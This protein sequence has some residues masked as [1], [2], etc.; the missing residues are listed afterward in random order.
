MGQ[1]IILVGLVALLWGTTDA[2]FKRYV[3]HQFYYSLCILVNLLGS[4][5]FFLL[6]D[7]MDVSGLQTLTNSLSLIV[8]TLVSGFYLEREFRA[9]T[10]LGIL[11]VLLGVLIY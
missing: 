1:A 4:V 5:I 10:V 3:D 6:S 2:L 9:H 11:F 8:T 7:Q